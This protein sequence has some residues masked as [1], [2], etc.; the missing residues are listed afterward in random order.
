M[1]DIERYG[2][3]K[4]ELSQ[5]RNAKRATLLFA[6]RGEVV[7]LTL[8]A[9]EAVLA[10]HTVNASQFAEALAGYAQLWHSGAP[11]GTNPPERSFVRLYDAKGQGVEPT[12]PPHGPPKG[13]PPVTWMMHQQLQLFAAAVNL[14]LDRSEV[15]EIGRG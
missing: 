13:M 3:G 15:G 14:E 6:P 1:H 7:T 5:W 2:I 8:V 12:L 11:A 4:S 10:R 9:D